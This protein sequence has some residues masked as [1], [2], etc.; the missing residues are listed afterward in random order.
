MIVAPGLPWETRLLRALQSWRDTAA[1]YELFPRD[2]GRCSTCHTSSYLAV[3]DPKRY[4]PHPLRHALLERLTDLRGEVVME[5]FDQ[6]FDVH[7]SLGAHYRGS[8][9]R[10][11]CPGAVEA[12]ENYT[13]AFD[14]WLGDRL[15]RLT[16]W[17]RRIERDRR[18]RAEHRS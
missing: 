7:G 10:D 12:V 11:T 3:V 9:M 5:L 17:T 13:T 16:F 1:V 15:T 14:I 2:R 6:P 18:R 8:G 4:W